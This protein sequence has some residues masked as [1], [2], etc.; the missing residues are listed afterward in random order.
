ML[1]FLPKFGLKC[2]LLKE[3]QRFIA[4]G[5]SAHSL[6]MAQD[7]QLNIANLLSGTTVQI[8]VTNDTSV[9]DVRGMGM[10]WTMELV[11]DRST[12]QPLRKANERYE[13]TIVKQVSDFLFTE[14]NVYMPSD[15]FGLWIVPPLIVNEEEIEFLLLAIEDALSLADRLFAA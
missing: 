13:N 15:K 10:F 1:F 3:D 4:A 12:K 9:G 2:F 6:E 7:V 11:A 8:Q 14:R 5:S